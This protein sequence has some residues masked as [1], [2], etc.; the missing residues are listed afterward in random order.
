MASR[1]RSSRNL[2]LKGPGLLEQ[3][4][5]ELLVGA[6]SSA[7]AITI[8]SH[9]DLR[10]PSH[11][12]AAS[13]WV[14]SSPAMA[15]RQSGAGSQQWGSDVSGAPPPPPLHRSPAEA[16]ADVSPDFQPSPMDRK[17]SSSLASSVTYEDGEHTGGCTPMQL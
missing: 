4:R 15:D 2:T 9:E 3:L 12:E 14:Q 6:S 11:G 16:Q 7:P 17:G 5:D 10:E 1:S 8:P 13:S